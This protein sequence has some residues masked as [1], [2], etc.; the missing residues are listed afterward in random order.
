[1]AIMQRHLSSLARILVA[2]AAVCAALLPA[3]A[4]AA[5]EEP[6]LAAALQQEASAGPCLGEPASREGDVIDLQASSTAVFNIGL[7][8]E[9][10]QT[11]ARKLVDLINQARAAQGV[12][13]LTYDTNLEAV[14]MLRERQMRTVRTR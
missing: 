2:T 12:R 11:E 9:Y 8:G 5:E 10:H 3:P 7:I 1:M 6:V 14:A 4:L 13:P